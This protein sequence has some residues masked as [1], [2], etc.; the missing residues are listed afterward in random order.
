MVLLQ[1]SAMETVF[2]L[3]DVIYIV[4]IIGGLLTQWFIT[5]MR[6]R[7]LEIYIEDCKKE[8][9]RQKEDFIS[10][11]GSRK[12]AFIELEKKIDNKLD[13]VRQ[14][15]VREVMRVEEKL[16]KIDEKMDKFIEDSRKHREEMI[17]IVAE[18]KK[19]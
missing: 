6:I 14:D 5:K 15:N 12:S 18:I 7:E 8:S 17:K 4:G 2:T 13:M 19:G 16:D 11:K 1:T 3:K 10:Y 9:I